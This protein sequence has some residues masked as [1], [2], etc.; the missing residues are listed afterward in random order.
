[1]DS[2][3]IS[4]VIVSYNTGEYLRK[5]LV[6]LREHPTELLG[7]IIVVDNASEDGSAAMVESEF[8]EVRLVRNRSNLGYAR[9][10]NQ[11]L[12]EAG[13]EYL[14][15]LNPD[16]ETGAEA[17]EKLAAF[18]ERTP[19]AGLA[20][21]R[22]LNPDGT[23]QMSCRTF[24]T[25]RTVL[26][27]RTVLGK[28]F[29]NSRPVREHLMLDWDHQSNRAVDWVTGACMMVRRKAY[30]AVGG[31]DERFFLY[32]EDVDWCYRMQ[33]HG[34]KV[35]Y[36]GQSE[37]V[38]HYR[39]QSASL[40]SGRKLMWHLLSTF[41]FYDKWGSA[42]YAL[43]RERGVLGQV[44]KV[45]LDLVLINA[46]FL[47][48]FYLRYLLRVVMV[49]PVYPVAT[50]REFMIFLNLVCLFSFVFSGLY[51]RMRR[52]GFAGDLVSISRALLISSLVIMAATYLTR[53]I[54]YSRLVVIMFWPIAALLV[55]FG[56]AV[57]RSVHRSIRRNLFDLTRVGVVGRG[58]KAEETGRRLRESM[59]ESYDFVGY[60]VPE[61]EET[62]EGVRPVIG[63]TDRVA[64]VVAEHRLQEVVIND[65]QL[66][67][68]EVGRVITAVRRMGAEVKV[69]SEVTDILI[70][71]SLMGEIAGIPVVMFPPTSLSGA[72]L[73]SKY[74]A[75]YI[76][77][78]AGIVLLVLLLPV[79][80]VWQVLTFRNFRPWA[81]A[82]RSLGSVLSGRRSLVGPAGSVEGERLKPGI[83]GPWLVGEASGN[84]ER[85]KLDI[86]YLQNW[87]LSTD[88]EI[89]LLTLGRIGNLLG[90]RDEQKQGR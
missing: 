21:A 65:R 62:V 56:R 78:V 79:V 46:A 27:R 66:S 28:L 53:T 34:W 54:A 74:A 45:A 29:P 35:Y 80:A 84:M 81:A 19:D 90:R 87:S 69:V 3:C 25:F 52:G 30:E 11:G 70:R 39:R 8:P 24:Y 55:T 18:M 83:T 75:D 63:S 6:S 82:M 4:I 13:G 23:L 50:Y 67:R 32:L 88:I 58:E 68:A 9:A 5:C 71:G 51:R 7:E 49:K 89:V 42:L 57:A 10:V 86:Y 1:M 64:E 59:A 37:M 47:I 61:G 36:V 40:L 12:R 85:E 22:L 43:K 76:V 17:L 72:R 44:G 20:A 60:I 73:V 31:M 77:S 16:V 26:L 14:L 41:R 33:K 38:H 2:R 48:A 15:V